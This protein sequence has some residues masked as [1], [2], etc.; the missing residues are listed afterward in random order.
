MQSGKTQ[1]E[2]KWAQLSSGGVYKCGWRRTAGNG[3]WNPPTATR[4]ATY[5]GNMEGQGS[6]LSCVVCFMVLAALTS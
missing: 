6:P 4:L 3:L 2:S 1:H 5:C